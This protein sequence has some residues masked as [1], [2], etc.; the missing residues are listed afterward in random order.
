MVSGDTT[1]CRMTA[2]TLHSHVHY[3]EIYGIRRPPVQILETE[4]CSNSQGWDLTPEYCRAN[5]YP[6]S[7]FPPRRARPGPG[8]HSTG[9]WW[10][11]SLQWLVTCCLSLGW[12]Q[13]LQIKPHTPMAVKLDQEIRCLPLPLPGKGNFKSHGARPVHLIITMKWIRTSRL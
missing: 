4:I 11:G 9:G 6:W 10:Q 13:G 8:P 3:K 2:V 12:W 7:S 5:S 1:P